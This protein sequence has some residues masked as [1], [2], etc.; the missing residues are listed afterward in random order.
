MFT[1]SKVKVKLLFDVCL[2][3][4]LANRIK[5]TIS[6]DFN[7]VTSY[8]SRCTIFK[9][10][11]CSIF[12]YDHLFCTETQL[13]ADRTR[14]SWHLDFFLN[15]QCNMLPSIHIIFLNFAPREH[16]FLKNFILLLGMC[17]CCVREKLTKDVCV[18]C[19]SNLCIREK[20]MGGGCI[21]IT[22]NHWPLINSIYIQ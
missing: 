4:Y 13:Q 10:Q 1:V 20:D 18:F 14:T 16:L 17:V 15:Y 12:E 3:S 8:F 6:V 19:H 9:S 21:Q 11:K 7:E 5:R 2:I 22:C